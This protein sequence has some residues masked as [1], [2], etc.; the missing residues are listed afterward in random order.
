MNSFERRQQLRKLQRQK[1]A[2]DKKEIST[3]S[4]DAAEQR[5]REAFHLTFGVFP[6]V[7]K[8]LS[9]QALIKAAD[10]L[11]AEAHE[12]ELKNEEDL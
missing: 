10:G 6:K 11:F 4:R 12:R 7:I 9:T 8:S 1:Y 2:K 3:I 5:Y